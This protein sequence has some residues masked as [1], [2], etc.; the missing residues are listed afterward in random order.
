MK[1]YATVENAVNLVIETLEAKHICS[2]SDSIR[3]RVYSWYNNSD[4]T[5]PQMLAACALEGKDWFPGATYEYMERAK[6]FW[7]PAIEEN[8]FYKKGKYIIAW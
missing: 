2:D 1:K 6:E 7:F 3:K 5:D 4:V 8:Y